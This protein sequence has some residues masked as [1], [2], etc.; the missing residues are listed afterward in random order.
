MRQRST[1]RARNS[2]TKSLQQ[3]RSRAFV[4]LHE[5][6]DIL[7][8]D[9]AS[10]VLTVP[11]P[12]RERFTLV[13][14]LSRYLS[15]SPRIT[16]RALVVHRLD[17]DTS[18]LLVF[19]KHEV[20]RAR[21][22]AG[23][24]SHERTYATLVA[25]VLV[26]DEGTIRSRLLTTRAL[27]RRSATDV[28]AGEDA[29][30]HFRVLQRLVGATLLGVTLETGRRNQ[31]RVH[32]KEAGHPI[33]GDERYGGQHRHRLW[34]D[35]LLA[36]HAQVLAFD[37]PRTGAAQRF[38]TPLPAAFV[39]FLQ[40]AQAGAAAGA[41]SGTMPAQR[42]GRATQARVA[43]RGDKTGHDDKPR[44]RRRGPPA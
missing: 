6:D 44:P 4:L 25:G 7:V 33:L 39:R 5:D 41:T 28:E 24:A 20:A 35:R 12:R 42:E 16:K 36:L 23:W 26:S 2:E 17:R 9:K 32:L 34:D 30:T 19:A 27:D 21:L 37:H 15:R 14:E 40:R 38:E 31:I 8:V 11:T 13:D 43:G 10:G 18:G 29:T 22:V 1:P 3:T